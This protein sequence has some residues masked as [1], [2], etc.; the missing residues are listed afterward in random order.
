[1]S[2]WLTLNELRG[3]LWDDTLKAPEPKAPPSLAVWHLARGIS[4][5]EKGRTAEARKEQ[6][7]FERLRQTLDRNMQWDTNRFG[8]V[9]DLA[10]VVL[11]ARLASTPAQAVPKWRRAVTIQDRLV[12]DEPP[13]WYYPVRE[14]L[15][16]A[17]LLSGDAAGA[18]AVFRE[19]MR[20]SPN[21]GRILFGLLE[22][23]KAQ[24]KTGLTGW[25]Q[26]EFDT[27][28]KSADIQLHLKD[29]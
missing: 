2:T 25:V 4:L 23:L 8:D 10:S 15:G 16:G 27:A 29:L 28:W 21:N 6:V 11:D 9:M 18:E 20:R 19:G 26:R 1:M 17:L 7:E 12:Y 5:A 24:K 22:S 13:A 14:S 3:N